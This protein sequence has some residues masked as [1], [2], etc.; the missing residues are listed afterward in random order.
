MT[1]PN[2]GAPSSA[3]SGTLNF[4]GFPMPH[5]VSPELQLLLSR[6][7]LSDTRT[8]FGSTQ[9]TPSF[10]TPLP[11]ITSFIPQIDPVLDFDMDQDTP[12]DPQ[13]PFNPE[14]PPTTPQGSNVQAKSL[15]RVRSSQKDPAFG[16]VKGVYRG[17]EPL[18]LVR[19]RL[20]GPPI[21]D[22]KKCSTHF[23]R[24][25]K[26]LLERC[27]ELSNETSCW[28]FVTAHHANAR[29]PFYH[30]SSPRLLRDGRND[31]EEITNQFNKL[32]LSL[33]AARNTE[34]AGLHKQLLESQEQQA[35]TSRELATTSEA[36][37]RAQNDAESNRELIEQ[38]DAQI[39]A[40][41]AL[42][43]QSSQ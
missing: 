10:V 8:P 2:H 39:A 38:K 32:F 11:A 15:V 13:D 28:L 17:S 27:E 20:P 23:G 18:E 41:K 33:V 3:H 36:L 1:P 14:A 40:Y 12:V 43:A 31:V 24:K 6:P 7:L 30:Y 26:D 9:S 16:K 5:N 25:I 4:L 21:T 35:S 37:E 29:E 19:A 22:R 34:A 42:L